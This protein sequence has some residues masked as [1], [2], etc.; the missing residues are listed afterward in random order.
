MGI[1]DVD[2]IVENFDED[3]DNG[4]IDGIDYNIVQ[5]TVV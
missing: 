4:G 3:I 2:P 1:D 5:P